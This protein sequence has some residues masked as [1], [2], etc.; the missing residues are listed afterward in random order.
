V[1]VGIGALGAFI[2]SKFS[3]K[4]KE[5]VP[6]IEQLT[7]PRKPKKRI[8]ENTNSLSKTEKSAKDL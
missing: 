4:E 6:P 5:T 1:G 3:D 7:L 8:F 2:A